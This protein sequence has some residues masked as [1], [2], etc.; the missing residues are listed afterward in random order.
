MLRQTAP[1]L[2][3]PLAISLAGCSSGAGAGEPEASATI[4]AAYVEA[5]SAPQEDSFYP[6]VGDPGVDALHYDLDLAWD[7]DQRE[8]TG[9]ATITLRATADA[10]HLQLD[11]AAPLEVRSAELDGE[12]VKSSHEGK[13]LLIAAEVEKDGVHELVLAYSGK[14]GPVPS[15][16]KRDDMAGGLGWTVTETGEVWTM[17]EP[18]GA[19]SW[20]PVND[21]PSDK[22]LY[23]FTLRVPEKWVGVANGVLT[24]RTKKGGQT[25]TEWHLDSPAAA[26]LVTVAIGDYVE[27]KD[28][29][30]SGVPVSV[31]TGPGDTESRE[32]LAAIPATLDWLEKRLGPYP[33]SSIGAVVVDSD[34]AMETQTMMTFG[35]SPYSRTGQVIAHELAHQWYGNQVTPLD[36][37]DLWMNEGMALYLAEGLWFA[38]HG[39]FPLW[40]IV[41]NWRMSEPS[42]RRQAGPPGNPDRDEFAASVVYV[43]P[44][45]MWHELRRRIGAVTFDRMVRA[46][47]ASQADGSANREEYLAWIEEQTGQELTAFFDEWLMSAKSPTAAQPQ[48]NQP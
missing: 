48:G 19:Y 24:S 34:S 32:A 42:L 4:P 35:N 16:S 33:F 43:A 11:F 7:A 15:P 13:D 6:A 9:T 8:L 25:I 2:V 26:Y 14:P 17:Q 40:D 27:T 10:D 20:Y 45:L 37:S 1:A 18:Y 38:E 46:W 12:K 28:E 3:L 23:D 31:W 36:W 5:K 22:A 29:S 41:D 30:P 21:H 47:P 44:A 39:E